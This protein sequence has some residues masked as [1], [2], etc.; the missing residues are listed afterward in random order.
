M[1]ACVRVHQCM[2]IYVYIRMY[3]IKC[4]HTEYLNLISVISVWREI[5]NSKEGVCKRH[6]H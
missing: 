5:E 2:C 3:V 4:F 6:L 1:C